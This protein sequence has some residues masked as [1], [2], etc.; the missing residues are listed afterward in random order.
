MEAHFEFFEYIN[1][2]S[3]RYATSLAA[4]SENMACTQHAQPQGTKRSLSKAATCSK[5]NSSTLKGKHCSLLNELRAD[6]TQEGSAGLIGDSLRQQCFPC[7]RLPVQN[8]ACGM[9]IHEIMYQQKASRGVSDRIQLF[10]EHKM[11]AP[12]YSGIDVSAR[13][14]WCP[15]AGPKPLL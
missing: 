3:E 4:K 8:N 1:S 15:G 9:E 5:N 7:S 13:S 10:E 12:I 11:I 6:D 14:P 2:S